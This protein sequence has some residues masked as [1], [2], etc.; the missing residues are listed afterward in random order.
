MVESRDRRRYAPATER[1]RD[2]ILTVLRGHL[3]PRG[4]VLEIA[5]GTGQHGAYFAPALA[6]RHWLTSDPSPEARDSIAAWRATVAAANLHGPL[7]LDVT[8][9]DW[10]QT[11]QTWRQQQ[12]LPPITAVV[13]INLIHISPWAA[14][15]GLMQGAA[16]LL[17]EGG[18]LYLYGPYHRQGQATAPSNVAFDA[19]L[20]A[21]DPSWGV[22]ELDAVV[23]LARR[24]HVHLTQVVDMPANNLSVLG[25]KRSD[26]TAP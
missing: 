15:E 22:R 8:Q 23:A 26:V 9:P 2:P 3:P 17:P 21:Q 4:T 18:L 6:P 7:A 19:S 11:A 14:C 10:P 12:D 13:A 24:H 16:A 20:R 25:H 1:N 5:S